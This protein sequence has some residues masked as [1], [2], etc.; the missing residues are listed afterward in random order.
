MKETTKESIIMICLL[1]FIAIFNPTLAVI[2]FFAWSIYFLSRQRKE[3]KRLKHT[4]KS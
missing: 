2:G 1:I 4:S 3:R